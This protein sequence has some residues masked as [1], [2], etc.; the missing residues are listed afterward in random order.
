MV[1]AVVTK[2]YYSIK[3]V[4][5]L[6]GETEPTLRYWEGEFR[7][8]ISPERKERGIRFYSEKDIDDVRLIKYLIRDCGFTLEGVRKKLKNNKESAVRQAK[9]IQRLKNIRAELNALGEA[10]SEAEK[11]NLVGNP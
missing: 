3:E 4:S 9:V 10:M 7:N 11:I 1:K 2:M 8:V 5:S 6:L